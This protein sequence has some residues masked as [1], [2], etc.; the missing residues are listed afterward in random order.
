[1]ENLS[2]QYSSKFPKHHLAVDLTIFGYQHDQLK[3]L[4]S[5]R[6]FQ[7]N[8]GELSL[9]GGWVREE[10]T[11]EE[12]ATRVLYQ[13]TGLQDIYLEQVQVFSNPDRDPGGRV[14]SVILYAMIP[15]DKHD[16]ALAKEHGAKW[17]AF[18]E[19]PKLIFDHDKMVKF[20]HE[21]LK[22][23]ASFEL[24]GEDLLPSRFTILQLRQLYEAVFQ[25]EFDPGNFRKKILG[26][27]VM[28][29]LNEKNTIDSKKGAYYYRF[30]KGYREI[31]SERIVKI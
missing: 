21:R 18:E 10:E 8:Q 9:I 22:Q 4:L 16:K 15:L 17:Y 28:E 30:R 5:H 19:M 11:V 2:S 13:I 1:M 14:I 3:I 6:R 7:P 20:A 24:I 23:K 26:L 25:R 29:R 27:K 12:A 31:I